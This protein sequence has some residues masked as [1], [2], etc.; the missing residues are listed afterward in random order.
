VIR[1]WPAIALKHGYNTAEDF[2]LDAQKKF[3]LLETGIL[4]QPS[5]NLLIINASGTPVALYLLT[6]IQGIEDGL[7]PIEDSHLL[8][9]HGTPK[10]S[11]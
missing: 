11:R 10:S 8:L 3:S 1:I 7:M 6:P 9:E 2:K 4:D 5:S